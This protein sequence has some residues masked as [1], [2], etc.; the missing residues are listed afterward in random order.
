MHVLV[1]NTTGPRMEANEEES[2]PVTRVR[3]F[4]TV[5][6]QPLSPALPYHS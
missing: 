1:C 4:G 3:S 5:S 2:A 6:S